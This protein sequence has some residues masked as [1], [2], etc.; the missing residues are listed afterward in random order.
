MRPSLNH[1]AMKDSA[2]GMPCRALAKAG[3]RG[4]CALEVA[5]FLAHHSINP[6][7]FRKRS[8]YD[9]GS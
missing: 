8:G 9:S 1:N 6:M 7:L 5:P 4:A 2:I 3:S